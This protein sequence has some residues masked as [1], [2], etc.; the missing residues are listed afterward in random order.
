[1]AELKDIILQLDQLKREL[2]HLGPLDLDMKDRLAQKIRLEWNYHSNV[3]EGNQLD[4]GETR[5]LLLHGLTAS[6]KPLKDHLD[7]KG[8]NDALRKLEQMADREV[9][10]TEKLI[11]DFHKIIIEDPFKE[12]PDLV[13]GKYKKEPN[14]LYNERNERVD[15]ASPED[16]P[17]LLNELINWTNNAIFLPKRK[18]NKYETHPILI[19]SIFHLRFINIHPFADGNGRICRIIMN[20]ILIQCGFPPI[21]IHNEDR[22]TYFQAIQRSREEGERFLAIFLGNQLIKSLQ[23]YLKAARGEAF[24]EPDDLDKKLALLQKELESVDTDEEVKWQFNHNVLLSILTGWYSDLIKKMVPAIVKFNQFFVETQHS[25]YTKESLVKFKDEPPE[26]SLSKLIEISKGNRSDFNQ[27]Q[28][29]IGL[30]THFG[31]FKK[32]GLNSFGCNYGLRIEFETIKYVV[33]VDSFLKH[34]KSS[35][36]LYEKLLHKSLTSSEIDA[37]VTHLTNAIY[38]HIDFHSREAGLR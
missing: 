32:G 8:H 34:S 27:Y 29:S 21:I 17:S 9:Q 36:I 2:D 30:R 35:T 37:I 3:I 11:K 25:L 23:L 22:K 24:E 26:E 28:Y 12:Y 5:S 18:K 1:M 13:T 7:M 38:Q 20:I 15:F 33:K 31:S 10:I 16:V 14:Y 19:A 4:W 6:G